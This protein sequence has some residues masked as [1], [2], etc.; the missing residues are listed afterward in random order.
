MAKKKEE[1]KE[2]P[3][4]EKKVELKLIIVS[5]YLALL[6]LMCVV[7]Y[8]ISIK[9]HF[10][11]ECDFSEWRDVPEGSVFEFGGRELMIYP[12]D[13]KCHFEFDAPLYIAIPMITAIDG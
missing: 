11:V 4:R 9:T 13:A 10:D 12:D 1:Q 3:V 5:I 7:V 8:A 6:V 2:E